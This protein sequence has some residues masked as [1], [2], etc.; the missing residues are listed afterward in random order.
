MSA[1]PFHPLAASPVDREA[2]T[3]STTPLRALSTI[4]SVH[5]ALHSTAPSAVMPC[6]HTAQLDH[7]MRPLTPCAMSRRELA[8]SFSRA[9]S[10][11]RCTRSAR[12]ARAILSSARVVSA[13]GL[14]TGC[15]QLQQDQPPVASTSSVFSGSLTGVCS[16]SVRALSALISASIQSLNG[17]ERCTWR[18]LATD[19][20]WATNVVA[21]QV[22]SST[23]FPNSSS[24]CEALGTDMG[25]S[26]SCSSFLGN[27]DHQ[28]SLTWWQ[29][30]PVAAP[31][32]QGNQQLTQRSLHPLPETSQRVTIPW[33]PLINPELGAFLSSWGFQDSWICHIHFRWSQ[34]V[35]VGARQAFHYYPTRCCELPPTAVANYSHSWCCLRC[36]FACPRSCSNAAL[37]WPL[38]YAN[39]CCL[40][41]LAPVGALLHDRLLP[42]LGAAVAAACYCC[43]PSPSFILNFGLE[44]TCSSSTSW[45]S[46]AYMSEVSDSGAILHAR[47][48]AAAT[49]VYST[50]VYTTD[51]LTYGVFIYDRAFTYDRAPCLTPCPVH[52][53]CPA[54]PRAGASL[55]SVVS[56]S[57]LVVS[58]PTV[59]KSSAFTATCASFSGAYSAWPAVRWPG[60]A[61]CLFKFRPVY[62]PDG[63]MLST[64]YLALDDPLLIQGLSQCGLPPCSCLQ[65]SAAWYPTA[66]DG[67]A[68]FRTL[69]LIQGLSFS[70]DALNGQLVLTILMILDD[71]DDPA[72][73]DATH[74][75]LLRC[76]T[77]SSM[78]PC[79][80]IHSEPGFIAVWYPTARRVCHDSSM[81]SPCFTFSFTFSSLDLCAS[82]RSEPSFI[83]VCYSAAY[84]GW[85]YS[86]DNCLIRRVLRISA[87]RTLASYSLVGFVDLQVFSSDH[88]FADCTIVDHS[89]TL[90]G[91]VIF[92]VP[93]DCSLVGCNLVGCSLA[94][95]NLPGY[96]SLKTSADLALTG[97]DHAGCVG[98]RYSVD[99]AFA[100][101]AHTGRLPDSEGDETLL[102]YSFVPPPCRSF[103]PVVRPGGAA[104][105]SS[106]AEDV[107]SHSR[108][109]SNASGANTTSIP[110]M[111]HAFGDVN[112]STL[113]ASNRFTYTAQH[114]SSATSPVQLNLSAL[115]P[116]ARCSPDLV[117]SL[118]RPQFPYRCNLAS[119]A[120]PSLWLSISD[121]ALAAGYN[122]VLITNACLIAESSAGIVT[123]GST[124]DAFT[125]VLHATPPL[126]SSWVLC[127]SRPLIFP[128]WVSDIVVVPVVM[129]TLRGTPVGM[130][131][132]APLLLKPMGCQVMPSLTVAWGLHAASSLLRFFG[133]II[134]HAFTARR[135]G[136]V[137]TM[138]QFIR[139][140][141][142]PPSQFYLSYQLQL[143]LSLSSASILRLSFL[144]VCFGSTSA[145]IQAGFNFA[146][147]VCLCSPR[148]LCGMHPIAWPLNGSCGPQH[149]ALQRHYSWF[150]A[151][152]GALLLE[153]LPLY[154]SL[155]DLCSDVWPGVVYVSALDCSCSLPFAAICN[156]RLSGVPLSGLHISR[157][158][159]VK[160]CGLR[161]L[162]FGASLSDDSSGFRRGVFQPLRHLHFYASQ[163]G[164]R[165]SWFVHLYSSWLGHSWL[166]FARVY[167]SHWSTVGALQSA[168]LYLWI[169]LHLSYV[170]AV[171][172]MWLLV[173]LF[174]SC[175]LGLQLARPGGAGD[176]SSGGAA[177]LCNVACVVV[178]SLQLSFLAGY[179]AAIGF[180]IGRQSRM[181][182]A[183]RSVWF[184]VPS[185]TG[186][187]LLQSCYGPDRSLTCGISPHRWLV[188]LLVT[189]TIAPA[190]VTPHVALV[191][192][193]LWSWA[194]GGC[195]CG[196]PK[197]SFSV[198]FICAQFLIH[199]SLW[200]VCQIAFPFQA[201]PWLSLIA[202]SLTARCLRA[203]CSRHCSVAHCPCRSTHAADRHSSLP[204]S[205]QLVLQPTNALF[206]AP[207]ACVYCP[208]ANELQSS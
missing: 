149:S 148:L 140:A 76:S 146:S 204:H 14:H 124:A 23:Q 53:A 94:G 135:A 163:F 43:S 153:Y 17:L 54:S 152:C 164:C 191:S 193:R 41:G 31:Q 58:V 61:A 90:A 154:G 10:S 26:Y 182:Q 203:L 44:N 175:A 77:S 109:P 199:I 208:T 196:I 117:V 49:G 48:V 122:S 200:L 65:S 116:N 60:G 85:R 177:I 9:A 63:H 155:C 172:G 194:R 27:L 74:V 126:S 21:T 40:R 197:C 5:D 111:G 36:L 97:C 69:S 205:S 106:F 190:A 38:P 137:L 183:G 144:S 11:L 133:A 103:W 160:C 79:A 157:L 47:S 189:V 110:S 91:C 143:Q 123:T 68:G 180:V 114:Y 161:V 81:L 42:S 178:L 100:G 184:P 167:G 142:L 188:L 84:I 130:W 104:P 80:S 82:I 202:C 57:R 101:C 198:V 102:L 96:I 55:H 16:S 115:V 179:T 113:A 22:A 30:A 168:L 75:A 108:L 145:L 93:A 141:P 107:G 29:M 12:R 46:S 181:L 134:C 201:T 15:L 51:V 7:H 19:C 206:M 13:A 150:H 8:P 187:P 119:S 138:L 62:L 195:L 147:V 92:K 50:G 171:A 71:P 151:C 87:D 173:S 28:D 67:P 25:V 83:A 35:T 162:Q 99:Y 20:A 66:S 136:S 186:S 4:D 37:S 88:S 125:L 56:T 120:S 3:T 45:E 64:I 207:S 52:A 112:T 59:P 2:V 34:V 192:H 121:S 39:P 18:L 70:D 169:H 98:L 128:T 72:D 129:L 32:S 95:C 166:G 33:F 1:K 185:F 174:S 159:A 158:N 132:A 156:Y 139:G 170:E 131:C 105:A 118:V 86:A 6:E 24:S 165:C 73:P 176:V 89:F 78:Y 127:H